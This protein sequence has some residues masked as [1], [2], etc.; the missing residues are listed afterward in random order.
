MIAA[1]EHLED[2]RIVHLAFVGLRA[3]RHCRDLDMSDD[4]LMTRKPRY[5]VAALDLDVIEIELHAHVGPADERNDGGSLLG[6]VQEIAGPV[7]VVCRGA[8]G[9]EPP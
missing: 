2:R 7:A 3:G 9:L 6:P 1:I 5:Q 4:L 8:S